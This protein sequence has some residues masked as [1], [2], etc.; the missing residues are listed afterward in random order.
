MQSLT[1]LRR[2]AEEKNRLTSVW[3]CI[4]VK[5]TCQLC[6]SQIPLVFHYI[7]GQLRRVW[8]F[9]KN[10]NIEKGN[11]LLVQ[12]KKWLVVLFFSQ[13]EPKGEALRGYI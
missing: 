4:Y 1:T 10:R 13:K 2:L 7:M 8:D 12:S 3:Q 9:L 5:T 11:S 6:K